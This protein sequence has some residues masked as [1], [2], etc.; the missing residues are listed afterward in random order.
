MMKKNNEPSAEALKKKKKAQQR[1]LRKERYKMISL[2]LEFCH[3]SLGGDFEKFMRESAR[4]SVLERRADTLEW[5]VAL[6][7]MEAYVHFTK[8]DLS[9]KADDIAVKDQAR[10][11]VFEWLEYFQK[12]K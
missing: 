4:R 3:Q 10:E 8:L 6:A 1:T 9:G 12:K 2:C 5:A 11:E 7:Y